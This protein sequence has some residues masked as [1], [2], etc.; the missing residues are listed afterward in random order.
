MVAEIGE[1]LRAGQ[2]VLVIA[3]TARQWFSFNTQEERFRDSG[4]PR[5]FNLG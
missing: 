5:P 3:E 2:P 1:K 4:R